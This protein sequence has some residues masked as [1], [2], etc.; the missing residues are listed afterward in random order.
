M[1]AEHIKPALAPASRSNC[2]AR[3]CH[4]WV[5]EGWSLGAKVKVAQSM[6]S[7]GCPLV[8]SEANRCKIAERAVSLYT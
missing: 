7:V 4:P 3:P 6:E 1:G 5:A 2:G 8:K